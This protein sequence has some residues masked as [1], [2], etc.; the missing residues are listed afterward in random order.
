[1]KI[2]PLPMSHYMLTDNDVWLYLQGV[3]VRVRVKEN[4]AVEAAIWPVDRHERS[5]P[6]VSMEHLPFAV[7]VQNERRRAARHE[8]QA[9]PELVDADPTEEEDGL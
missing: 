7:R 1:M 6:Y 3:R 5:D 8:F 4:G 9:P 2:V